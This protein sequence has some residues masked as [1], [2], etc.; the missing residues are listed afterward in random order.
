MGLFFAPLLSGITMIKLFI[1]FY[2]RIIYL[3]YL[4]RPSK[5][6]YEVKIF[7]EVIS[8][9]SIHHPGLQDFLPA[10]LFPS[11]LLPGLLHTPGLHTG[12]HETLQLLRALQGEQ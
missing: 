8:H 10:E 3:K 12:G 7:V 5:T 6:L 1:V 2:L 9:F 4:C 11:L